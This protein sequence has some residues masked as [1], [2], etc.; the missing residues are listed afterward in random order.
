MKNY[1]YRL[2]EWYTDLLQKSENSFVN[3]IIFIF[4]T[5]LSVTIGVTLLVILVEFFI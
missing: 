1:L 3:K 2:A 5:V 4:L